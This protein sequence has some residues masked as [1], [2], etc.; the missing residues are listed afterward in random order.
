MNIYKQNPL[1]FFLIFTIYQNYILD[2]CLNKLI[3]WYECLKDGLAMSCDSF[4][5]RQA[6]D[7]I[8]QYEMFSGTSKTPLGTPHK[9]EEHRKVELAETEKKLIK[10]E[11]TQKGNVSIERSFC[12]ACE[13]CARRRCHYFRWWRWYHSQH[14]HIWR[15]N[16]KFEWN[17]TWSFIS[18]VES[19][20]GAINIQRCSIENQKGTIA[21]QSLWWKRPSGSQRNIFE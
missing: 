21:M 18:S 4:Y 12:L 5:V 16:G 2:T 20:K 1:E 3:V 10:D 7:S 14:T 17:L 13:A 19:Q 8:S 11:K 6:I 15:S 9:S